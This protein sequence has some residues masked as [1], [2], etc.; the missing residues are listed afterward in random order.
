[1]KKLA[2]IFASIFAQ[3][4]HAASIDR[5]VP[6]GW[7]ILQKA[8]G[9]LNKDGRDDVALIVYESNPKNIVK[10]DSLGAP[11]LNTNPR[12]LIIAFNK[13]NDD[14][15]VKLTQKTFIPSEGSVDSPC[16]E[17]PLAES[18]PISIREGVLRI[19]LSYWYSCGTWYTSHNTYSFRYD[20]P[21]FALI[22]YDTWDLHRASGEITES[23]TNFL[24]NRR[25]KTIGGSIEDDDKKKSHLKTTWEKLNVKKRITLENIEDSDF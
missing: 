6:A 16:M 12:H 14:Y 23:S 17:D 20:E 18:E 21:Q 2:L 8:K 11:E 19:Q 13:G 3:Q 4:A 7:H 22:G 1:M 24:T 5:L 9:D 25:S 15:E 10:N